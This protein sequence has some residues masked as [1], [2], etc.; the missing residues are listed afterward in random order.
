MISSADEV[1]LRQLVGP[2]TFA[3]AMAYARRGAVMSSEW[4][5]DGS[6]V[7]GEVQ[8]G[9]PSPYRAS[10]E[11][12][13]SASAKLSSLRALCSCPVG[14]NCKHAVALLLAKG[15]VPSGQAP[16]G[17]ALGGRA[18]TLLKGS[19]AAVDAR[20]APRP[21]PSPPPA[22]EQTLLGLVADDSASTDDIGAP[23]VGLQFELVLAAQQRAGGPKTG[24]RVRLRPVVPNRNGHWVREGISWS[25]LDYF[26]VGRRRGSEKAEKLALMKELL[27]LSRLS[28]S[29]PSYSYETEVWL[30]RINSRRLWDLLAE[31][32]EIQVPLV[33]STRLG[34]P[35]TVATAPAIAAIDLTRSG[36]DLQV[37]PQVEVDGQLVP[38]GSS[39]LIGSPPHG[40]AWWDEQ[41]GT[42]GRT[43]AASTPPLHLAPF[44]RALD[45]RL[46]AFLHASPLKVPGR[47]E[48]RFLEQ[49]CSA[50][51]RRVAVRSTD[52]SVPL[53]QPAPAILVLSLA[54]I[55]EHRLSLAWARGRAG[56]PARAPLWEGARRQPEPSP[57]D[58]TGVVTR[59]LQ[60]MPELFE[61]TPWGAR[62]APTATLEGMAAVRFVSEALPALRAVSGLELDLTEELPD[63][64]EAVEPPVVTLG[65][66]TSL[67]GDWFDLLV[68]V[69]VGGE[70]VPFHHLFLALAE[71]RSHLVLP[72]GTYFAL[73]SDELRQLGRLIG[74]ARSLPDAV[75][76]RARLSRFQVSLWEDLCR[77]GVVTGQ[78]QA[79]EAS[80][81]ALAEA[82]DLAEHPA[83]TG[84]RA[85]LRPYQKIGFNWLVFLYEH[86]LGGVLADDMGLGKTVQA[87][88]LMCHTKQHG[89]TAPYLVVAPTSVVANWAAE[90]GRFAPALD[91]VTVTETSRRRGV[92][93]ADVASHADLVVTS[94]ALFRLEYKDYEAVEWTGMFLDEAQF[95][96]NRHSKTY[97]QV[98]MLPVPF[99]VAVTG[100]PMENNLMELWSLLSI[101][102]PGLFATPEHFEEHY[103]GPIEKHGDADRLAQLRRRMRPLMLR[104]TKEQVLADLPQKQEQVLELDLN[105]RHK[106]LYQTYLARE[107]QKIL[108]LIGEM[109]KNRFEIF[110]SLTLLRQASLDVSLVDDK[111]RGVPSTKLDAL[112]EI[113]EDVVA[114]GHRVLVFS[115]FT[116]FLGEARRRVQAAGI[117]HCYL[118]GRTRKREAVISDFRNGKA[119]VF[120]ISLKAGGFGLNLTEADYCILLDP[121][122]NP[123]TEAQA[124]D[125][126]H[127]I[128]QTRKVMVYR[129]VAQETIEGKVMAL[130]AKK[131]ALFANVVDAGDFAS[132]ALTAADISGLVS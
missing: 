7:V 38:L 60:G 107:R 62:L 50:M 29:R 66:S 41:S 24:P 12:T 113:L 76:G 56:A 21:A 37:G 96:K 85:T 6:H 90:C 72:S 53:P 118:D 131:A 39:L 55:G 78:A 81:R 48:Q 32:H 16:G 33:S 122:W 108:G 115:Q 69:T 101:A 119:P 80:V 123:A 61:L 42:G 15:T 31:A 97:Q 83:P 19:S 20:G 104:R 125:R 88:A 44:P 99:K 110:R 117:D 114:E 28:S 93:L 63:Y 46:T 59:L 18:L 27:A 35:V 105:P 22:W 11:L 65:G 124:V 73:D 121:W 98:K 74:E 112:M 89:R 17:P 70:E 45:D 14:R 54:Y 2:V 58:A 30:E 106:R 91:V 57:E 109:S 129:L 1:S 128:G 102:A 86:H 130:K 4:R 84:L 10:V 51:T 87:L 120:L 82:T 36:R 49:L 94:Y 103:R 71:G 92:A 26:A 23:D 111:H 40:I 77:L 67:D 8:G 75:D 68:E 43:S 64:R 52:E 47:D 3:R 5:A 132:T 9:A 100:T 116:R 126:A 34:L 127:R 79:W 13:R 25:G 95:A